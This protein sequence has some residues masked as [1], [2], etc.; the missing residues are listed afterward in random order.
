MT[1]STEK[2]L[3]S[4]RRQRFCEIYPW[5]SS[6]TEA[7]KL[8]GYAHK[9]AR[10]QASRLLANAD[11]VAEIT[12]QREIGAERANI[13]PEDVI[14]RVLQDIDG[15]R[16]S[17]N[18]TS[19]MKGNDMLGRRLGIWQDSLKVKPFSD[20]DTKYHQHFAVMA[21]SGAN[22]DRALARQIFRG[23]MLKL[24]SEAVFDGGGRGF[25]DEAIDTLLNEAAGH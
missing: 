24:G 10:N 7:A 1:E 11:I 17:K 14:N 13:K 22:G 18:W 25:T 9:D 15:A 16:E 21:L 6:G 3:L 19:V 8:A 12:R 4:P 20:D 5:C 23:F 2:K